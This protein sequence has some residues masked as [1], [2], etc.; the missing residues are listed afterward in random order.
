M[1]KFYGDK[2]NTINNIY[3]IK[4]NF[5]VIVPLF[6]NKTLIKKEFDEKLLISNFGYTFE[7]NIIMLQKGDSLL[8]NNISTLLFNIACIMKQLSEISI[9]NHLKVLPKLNDLTESQVEF[10]GVNSFFSV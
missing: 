5:R 4:N 6:Y 1:L 9:S 2:I 8:E 3:K 10:V 7:E